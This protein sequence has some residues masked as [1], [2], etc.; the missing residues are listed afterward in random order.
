MPSPPLAAVA[1]SLCSVTAAAVAQSQPTPGLPSQPFAAAAQAQN[2]GAGPQVTYQYGME[3]VTI[4]GQSSGNYPGGGPQDV[5]NV[6]PAINRGAVSYEYR[7]SRYEVGR[8][9]WNAFYAAVDAVQGQTGQPL[10]YITRGGGLSGNGQYGRVGNISW[11]T[12][13]MYCNW[14]CNGQAQTRE[15]FMN[16]AYDV[17]TFGYF[18]TQYTDQIAHNPNAA[19]WIPTLDE[20]IHAAH[21]DPNRNGAGQG[22]WWQ[23]SITR[24]TMAG[25]GLPGHAAVFPF[26]NLPGEANA[27]FS[28]PN[29]AEFSVPLGAYSSIQSPW[30]LFDTIGQTTE[31]L[32]EPFYGDGTGMPTGRWQAGA[33]ITGALADVVWG[34]IG[35]SIGQT[36]PSD[37]AYWM[38]LRIAAAIPTPASSAIVLCPMLAVLRRHRR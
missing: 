10:P 2:G 12:A 5:P 1:L 16:G 9:S 32:E 18:G 33:Y 19:F 30:G 25:P 24:D 20:W 17:T 6:S 21:Y 23:Y 7:L 37:D 22:G 35:A 3:F 15:A 26:T 28:T 11:R 36:D 14:L 8:E 38:G 29:L 4:G 31:W 34:T 13:A 27:G